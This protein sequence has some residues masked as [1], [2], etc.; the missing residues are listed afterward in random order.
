MNLDFK[1]FYGLYNLYVIYLKLSHCKTI[2]IKKERKKNR[3]KNCN[4]FPLLG[5]NT[6]QLFNVVLLNELQLY[7]YNIVC[8]IYMLHADFIMIIV[9]LGCLNV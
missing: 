2:N 1:Y 5:G 8:K 6:Y 9:V 7:L 3:G 4:A